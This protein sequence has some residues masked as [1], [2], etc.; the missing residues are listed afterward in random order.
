MDIILFDSSNNYK[1]QVNVIKPKTYQNLLVQ[2]KKNIKNIP[3][4][5]E[6]FILDEYNKEINI[7]NDE[8]INLIE[9]I[10][11]IREIDKNNIEK[12]I[13]S[14]HYNSLSD[15]IQEKLEGKYNCLLCEI[16][17]KDEDPYLCQQ[18]NSIFHQNCLK[19][20]DNQSK[21]ENRNLTC[22]KCRNQLP[23]ENW[24][25]KLKY[26]EHR[27]DDSYLINIINEYKIK[28]NMY[29]NINILKNKKINELKLKQI[30]QIEL[31]KNHEKYIEKTLGIFYGILN[32]IN[33]IHNLLKL[34]Q[35]NKLNNLIKNHPLNYKNINLEDITSVFNEELDQFYKYILNDDKGNKNRLSENI[36]INKENSDESNYKLFSS[37]EDEN[38]Q[39]NIKNNDIEIENIN[40]INQEKDINNIENQ[41][42]KNDIINNN[43]IQ[44]NEFK[45]RINLIYN[46]KYKGKYIIFGAF[47][48]SNN[49]DKIELIINNKK[50]SLV[51]LA[52]LQKG[53]NT[54]TLIIKKK[55]SNLFNM[56]HSCEC[57]K[58]LTELKYLDIS[59][60]KDF[61]GIFYQCHSL[62]DIKFL[63]FWNVSNSKSFENMF[64][65]CSLLSDITSLQ[66]WDVSNCE[67]FK[68]M[69]SKCY[70]LSNIE[71]LKNW[72]VTKSQN[73]SRMFNECKIIDVKPLENWDV[74]NCINFRGMF[75]DCPLLDLEPLKK[76]NVSKRI[77]DDIK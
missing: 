29:N 73:F 56:F 18:C 10:L 44:V 69:F 51:S 65:E 22:P 24:N 70:S 54:I 40:Q 38:N 8:N 26:E 21:L 20:W 47:F 37:E 43:I 9:D 52:E 60:I 25:K 30:K 34:K 1:E 42:S 15:S 33:I 13:I 17:I 12:S 19:Q 75:R 14:G 72:V 45:N 4:V 59:D 39:K 71:P 36:I 62:R 7:D 57:I 49:K 64:F 76:W 58:D 41:E 28:N 35:N 68:K 48:V 67:N 50:S 77:L 2:I 32:K 16:F 61:S 6:L 46:V 11:F 27:I 74:S 5:Y 63:G 53:N 66:N 31:I 55:L 3:K 23:I